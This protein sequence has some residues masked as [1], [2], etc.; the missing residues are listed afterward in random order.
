MAV[1]DALEKIGTAF[2]EDIGITVQ[3]YYASKQSKTRIAKRIRIPQ[4]TN[5]NT[6]YVIEI[7]GIK[8]EV[9]RTYSTY[10]KGIAIT[11]I[12]LEEVKI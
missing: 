9:G 5:I 10:S 12:T 8:Y 7:S 6:N 4:N 11:D 1:H 3:E 2:Y